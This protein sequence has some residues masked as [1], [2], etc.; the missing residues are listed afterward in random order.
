MLLKDHLSGGSRGRGGDLPLHL[1]LQHRRQSRS[2]KPSD[3]GSAASS[4][5]VALTGQEI[6]VHTFLPPPIPAGHYFLSECTLDPLEAHCPHQLHIR[7]WKKQC[8]HMKR[9]TQWEAS[10]AFQKNSSRLSLCV[11]HLCYC[12]S[13]SPWGAV[14]QASCPK[15]RAQ[16]CARGLLNALVLCWKWRVSCLPVFPHNACKSYRVFCTR[17]FQ[18]P[19]LSF[20]HHWMTPEKLKPNSP[21]YSNL[22]QVK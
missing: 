20:R 22:F 10:L 21:T 6:K 3:K 16:T 12:S 14:G 4:M 13:G 11:L 9:S 15:T 7:K 8:Q 5:H 18:M 2:C 19:F 1:A 17:T